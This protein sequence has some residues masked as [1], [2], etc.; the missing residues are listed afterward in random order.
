[1]NGIGAWMSAF[2]PLCFLSVSAL[3]QDRPTAGRKTAGADLRAEFEKFLIDAIQDSNVASIRVN[4][5]E[6]DATYEKLGAD[7]DVRTTDPNW[8]LLELWTSLASKPNVLITLNLE[9]LEDYA[10]YQGVFAGEWEYFNANR[11]SGLE[12]RFLFAAR[13]VD[14]SGTQFETVY[15]NKTLTIP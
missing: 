5:F 12:V 3:A 9:R 8:V 1:M 14:K 4:R 10:R 13:L 6:Y 2:I 15:A 7:Y 11:Y